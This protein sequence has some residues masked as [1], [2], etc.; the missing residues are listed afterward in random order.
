MRYVAACASRSGGVV[1]RSELESFTFDG[2]P[3]KLI[4]ASTWAPR[5]G[6]HANHRS[7]RPP[8][9][10]GRGRLGGALLRVSRRRLR[11]NGRSV[12]GRR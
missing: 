10:S 5:N 2:E 9:A 11:C 1:T 7:T 3:I 4:D 12:I 8:P 6:R